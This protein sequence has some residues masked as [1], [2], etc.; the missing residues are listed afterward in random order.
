MPSA[1]S[2]E[3]VSEVLIVELKDWKIAI[4]IYFFTVFELPENPVSI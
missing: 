2:G 1:K 4:H 3:G